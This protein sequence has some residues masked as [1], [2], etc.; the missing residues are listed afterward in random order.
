MIAGTLGISLLVM[1]AGVA[2]AVPVQEQPTVTLVR[3]E[4]DE[5]EA[6]V[7]WGND[8]MRIE[9]KEN[10]L[11]IQMSSSSQT[12]LFGEQKAGSG[13]FISALGNSFL[14]METTD[15]DGTMKKKDY[16]VPSSV[17][18]QAKEAFESRKTER[19]V[20]Q[21]VQDGVQS[22]TE[23]TIQ[24]LVRRPEIWILEKTIHILGEMGV[25]GKTNKGA[26]LF[27]VTVLQ[28]MKAREREFPAD[29]TAGREADTET[30]S[31]HARR[32]DDPTPTHSTKTD[33]TKIGSSFS[34]SQSPHPSPSPTTYL[35]P[36]PNVYSLPPYLFW[37]WDDN[38]NIHL[39]ES[40][41]HGHDCIAGL[42]PYE[43]DCLG[44]CGLGCT[45]WSFVC[46][47]CCYWPGC[48][49]HDLYCEESFFSWSCLFIFTFDCDGY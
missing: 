12:F 35:A 31:R 23:Q 48:Y 2:M 41:H 39:C 28:L 21:L 47:D 3:E 16:I 14:S 10:R 4:N 18:E 25:T 38:W 27:Y 34:A 33:Q 15:N 43:T 36:S 49:Q 19:V 44:M 40:C 32:I 26:L 5:L 9:A 30:R 13:I 17:E 46:G 11:L 20:P 24:Q 42:C 6:S 29:S 45:C 22:I 8:G 1:L 7:A 37:C